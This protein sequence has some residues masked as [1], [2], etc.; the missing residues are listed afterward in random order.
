MSEPLKPCPFCGCT[1]INRRKFNGYDLHYHECDW[2]GAE[3]PAEAP[4]AD[5]PQGWN[6]RAADT[7][8]KE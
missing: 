2:C 7:E 3:G 1:T 4:D 8:K 5:P 6:C